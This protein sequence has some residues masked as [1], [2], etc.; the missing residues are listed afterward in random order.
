MTLGYE[1]HVMDKI[2]VIIPAYNEAASIGRV[3]DD[4]P[5]VAQVVVV[6]NG[7]S[8]AT[9]AVARAHGARVVHEP[10]RGYGAACLAGMAALDRD[11]E[12]VVFLDA[13]YSDHPE[14]LP[15]LVAPILSGEA[16]LVVGSRILG[17]R[18]PG[19]LPPHARWGN[20]L[21]VA[22][23]RLLYGV[24]F[25]DL[26]PF[27]AIRASSLRAL[28][29]GDPD[30]GWTVEMQARAAR[31]G[32]RVIEVPVSYRR[33]IGRS[34][35]SGTVRGSVL[36]GYKILTTIAAS[37]V[38]A[39]SLLPTGQAGRRLQARRAC[40]A[41]GADRRWHRLLPREGVGRPHAQV[42]L[43]VPPLPGG[44]EIDAHRSAQVSPPLLGGGQEEGDGATA[45]ARAEPI[46]AV[47]PTLD[48]EENIG[49]CL[50][51]LATQAGPLEVIVADG[52]STDRTVA[53]A[54][55]VPGVQVVHA[56]RGRGTQMNAG[57]RAATGE[58]LWFLHADCRPPADA[59]TAIR[60]TL[61]C[62]AVSGGAFRF[63]L[64]GRR[65]GYRVVE[66]GVRLRC[67]LFRLPYGD[68]GIFLRRSLFESLGGFRAVPILE[69]LYL[70]REL[71]R[72]G[73]VVT[74]PA[75]LP[76]SPR[77]CARDG[78]L[79]TVLRNQVLLLGERLGVA[80]ERL[81]RLRAPA[82]GR[83]A[84][85]DDPKECGEQGRS[86]IPPAYR[87][88]RSATSGP[89]GLPRRGRGSPV[90]PAPT[91]EAGR[92][93]PTS[94][95]DAADCHVARPVKE[96]SPSSCLPPLPAFLRWRPRPS[97]TPGR[98]GLFDS[99]EQEP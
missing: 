55:A 31:A 38:G 85:G 81:A 65:W 79:R 96:A 77:R 5:A 3:L 51:L 8:D 44:R 82:G 39:E 18:E 49:P 86:R 60:R 54:T 23:L 36:A 95:P 24:R 2:A 46:T 98:S 19:A 53:I 6:D 88:G 52:G 12:I 50:T 32:L 72:R 61:A 37:R 30:Y 68:Q 66:W 43:P 17:Q 21:A 14:E 4:L 41:E 42:Q 29:M 89:Q 47:I 26:G 73:R 57:A 94:V 70:V 22:L 74:L 28:G 9:T 27:R 7:S 25:T 91:R 64:A 67:R 1:Q 56:P 10:R 99:H 59:A 40:R 58:I 34:K 76:T 16:D 69:D 92:A 63:A 84:Q 20:G 97:G 45:P 93:R 15:R 87:T 33:R 78:I 35:V 80:P 75:P 11:A 62:D 13:D 90:A 48:E 71:R 83:E